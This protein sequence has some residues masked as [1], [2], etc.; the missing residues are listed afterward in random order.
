M[1][2]VFFFF[3]KQKT[4]SELRISDWSS[5]GCSSD[6][7]AGRHRVRLLPVGRGRRRL[8]AQG[9][10]PAVGGHVRRHLDLRR[11]AVAG[12]ERRH[13][14]PDG[15]AAGGML[16][17]TYALLAEMM[18]SRHRGRPAERRGGNEGGRTGRS[19]WL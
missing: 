5:D 18:P 6:L 12:V 17:V 8:W 4:A 10:D 11:D 2:V 16:P 19:R 14:L 15:A 9:V 3:F 13:V 1:I 7:R